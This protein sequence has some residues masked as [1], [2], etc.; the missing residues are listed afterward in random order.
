MFVT[1]AIKVLWEKFGNYYTKTETDA[2]CVN[3]TNNSKKYTDNRL[4]NYLTEDD[5]LAEIATVENRTRAFVGDSISTHSTD[6]NAHSDIRV[7]LQN[8]VYALNGSITNGDASTLQQAKEYTDAHSGESSYIH[9]TPDGVRFGTEDGR[10]I[11]S[12]GYSNI[13]LL[14]D[15]NP[16]FYSSPD[17]PRKF[18]TKLVTFNDITSR[19]ADGKTPI[20]IFNDCIPL[21]SGNK[22]FTVYYSNKYVEYTFKELVEETYSVVEAIEY[23]NDSSIKHIN[24]TIIQD[25]ANNRWNLSSTTVQ[26]TL[27]NYATV[28]KKLMDDNLL[29]F[30]SSAKEYTNDAI[31]NITQFDYQVVTSL[32]T[33]GV[34]GIMYLIAKTD[35]AE[36]DYYDEYIWVGTKYEHL[37]TTQVDLSNYYTKDEVN[38]L[39]TRVKGYTDTKTADKVTQS[40][41]NGLGN[42]VTQIDN[43]KLEKP[44][45]V[46]S[47]SIVT[48]LPTSPQSNVLYFVKEV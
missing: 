33:T 7:D 47:I 2:E 42:Y 25:K 22:S 21:E 45:G 17:S 3:A 14:G 24:Y 13:K 10:L 9:Q 12:N 37:G 32:P 35:G 38:I 18:S 39:E 30:E 27:P 1:K 46:E 28:N 43:R 29:E 6:R 8:A 23:Y 48:E 4:T 11:L 34:K 41:F 36:L 20:A 5:T 44:S 16:Q 19:Y 40:E 31:G 15:D 26:P